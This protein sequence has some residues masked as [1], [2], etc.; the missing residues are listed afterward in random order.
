MTSLELHAAKLDFLD[1]ILELAEVGDAEEVKAQV[2]K[3]FS[4]LESL[5]AD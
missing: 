4:E 3:L 2:E 5:V 1:S